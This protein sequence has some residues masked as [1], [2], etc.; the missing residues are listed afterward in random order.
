MYTSVK[1]KIIKMDIKTKHK[2][3]KYDT[4]NIKHKIETTYKEYNYENTSIK[5]KQNID[6]HINTKHIKSNTDIQC[7]VHKF[8]YICEIYECSG[9]DNYKYMNSKNMPYIT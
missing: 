5:R 7:L 4:P 3:I 2:K 8:S 9:L 1:R 6:I